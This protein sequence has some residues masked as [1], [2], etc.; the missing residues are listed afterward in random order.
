MTRN[1]LF[2]LGLVIANSLFCLNTC[3]AKSAE[4]SV[5]ILEKWDTAAHYL[6]LWKDGHQAELPNCKITENDIDDL[7]GLIHVAYDIELKN[8]TKK[9][10]PKSV[11]RKIVSCATNCHCGMYSDVL[12]NKRLVKNLYA[13]TLA[14]ANGLTPDQSIT[15][16]KKA[17][18]CKLLQRLKSA[19]AK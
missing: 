15:C 19:G 8:L 4:E 11:T 5:R 9:T 13:E 2:V 7:L 6:Q 17:S 1:K 14:K 12:E 18:P 16:I 10:I 3:L